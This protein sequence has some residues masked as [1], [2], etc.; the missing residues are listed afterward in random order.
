MASVSMSARSL[1]KRA[2]DV[3]CGSRVW[4]YHHGHPSLCRRGAE[5][6]SPRILQDTEPPLNV[7]KQSGTEE[8]Q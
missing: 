3:S 6:S 1:E 4:F 5:M 8:H 2:K 7:G